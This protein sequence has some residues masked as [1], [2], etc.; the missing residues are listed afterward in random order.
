MSESQFSKPF[1]LVKWV[2]GKRQLQGPILT[3]IAEVFDREKSTYFEPFVGGGAILFALEPK[4]AS[5]SDINSGL[6]NLY[7]RVKYDPKKVEAELQRF[8][9]EYNQLN[10]EQ[11]LSYFL[12]QRSVFNEKSGG[13]HVNREGVSGAACFLFLNK[14]GFNGMYRENAA[15]DFNIPF[16]KRPSVSLFNSSNLEAVSNLLQNVE[17]KT[18]NYFETIASAKA[19]DLVYFD[20]PYAPLSKTSSFEGYNSSNLGGFNQVE[21][22]DLVKKLTNRKVFCLVSNS[23]AQIIEELYEDF[24]MEPLQASRAI[25]ASAQGRKA[26]KE[27]LI[28]NFKQVQG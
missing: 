12:G 23:S 5:I 13:T 7:N 19:G 1:P 18:Q 16:G 6:V 17:V 27:Y 20:P 22:R 25:S 26:V 10:A 21:L 11:Q 15:G 3:K 8:E 24:T 28:D 2:G 14:S 9:K 4:K